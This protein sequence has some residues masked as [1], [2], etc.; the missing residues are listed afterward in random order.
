MSSTPHQNNFLVVYL[1][2]ILIF[3]NTRKEHIQ[4]I[5]WVLEQLCTHQLY[6]KM[7]KCE[8]RKTKVNYLGYII[9]Q[10]QVAP[11]LQKICVV[12][13]WPIPITIKEV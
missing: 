11:E 7:K 8:W 10:G 13:D 9:S 5:W 2:N 12:K 4:Y 3:F 6:T 1:D